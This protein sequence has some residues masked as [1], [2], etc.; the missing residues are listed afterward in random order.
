M[1]DSN[2]YEGDYCAESGNIGDGQSSSLMLEANVLQ[3]GDISFFVKVSSEASYDY[4]QFFIDGN[5][6]EEWA[7]EFGWSEVTYL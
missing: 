3:D 1:N 6:Q 5:M 4:L 7:G 2:P